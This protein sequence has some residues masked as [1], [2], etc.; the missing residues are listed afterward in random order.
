LVYAADDRTER[1]VVLAKGTGVADGAERWAMRGTLY[2]L[3]AAELSSW[4]AAL[5]TLPFGF[6]KARR[7]ISDGVRCC[8]GTI[9][10]SAFV[11]WS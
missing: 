1:V 4:M 7:G 10:E 9:D 6:G 8:I 2:L 3:P 11:A 5:D